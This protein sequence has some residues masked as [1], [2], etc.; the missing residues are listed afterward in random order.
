M[1]KNLNFN[2]DLKNIDI[3]QLT[4]VLKNV[5]FAALRKYSSLFPSLGLLL[6]ACVIF[7]LT[8]L[9]GGA[10]SKKMAQ[11]V[12][13]ANEIKSKLNQVPSEA[14][15][16]E[17]ERYYK[18][19]AEDADKVDAMAV[20]ASLRELICYD[21][22][23]FPEPTDKSTQIYDKF[24]GKY[25]AAIEKLLERVRAKD[26]PSEAEI[27]SRTGQGGGGGGDGMRRGEYVTQSTT[28]SVAQN[29][30]VDALCLQ[31]ANDIPVYANPEIFSWYAFWDKYTYQSK[32][33]SLLDCWYSQIAYWIYEDVIG[34]I[35]SAN[36]SSVKISQS[37]VKRLLGIR[38]DGPVL[39]MPSAMAGTGDYTPMMEQRT[40]G[41][42]DSQQDVPAYVKGESNFLPRPWTGRMCN[43]DIDVVHFAVSVVVD[44]KS[45][46][47]FMKEL[48]STKPHTY[49]EKFDPKGKP[50]SA[51][52]NQITILQFHVEPVIRDNGVHTYYRYGPDAVVRLNL[53]C[54]Y[55][56]ARQAYDVIKPEPVKKIIAA[57]DAAAQP[58]V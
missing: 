38:F 53:V 41:Q 8:L 17:A 32:E 28:L 36:S 34:T 5:N 43:A 4:G 24:G 47:P 2:L 1:A 19:H 45:V 3:K 21:P 10:V 22:I 54:E 37:P 26:A 31:R 30:M 15:V 49:L 52:H 39:V 11:S 16:A 46:M 12:R 25:R 40:F 56:F 9:V 27:R 48:C 50:E 33:Q 58:G 23:V 35:E 14:E 55:L 20:K 44:S 51:S 13:V 18:K 7:I 29:A 42:K 6:V 57:Q